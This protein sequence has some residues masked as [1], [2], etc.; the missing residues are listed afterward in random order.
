MGVVTIYF[1]KK[2]L[3]YEIF[4]SMVSWATIQVWSTKALLM[5][6]NSILP[7]SRN[8]YLTHLSEAIYFCV[9]LL[10]QFGDSSH[11]WH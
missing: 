9:V 4:R 1:P 6:S 5:W 2:L 8:Q 11:F 10:L 7:T 3:G